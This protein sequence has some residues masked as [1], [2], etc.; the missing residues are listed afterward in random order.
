M[1]SAVS[2]FFAPLM[3]LFLVVSKRLAALRPFI[4]VFVFAKR[5]NNDYGNMI[6]TSFCVAYY[7]SSNWACIHQRNFA[8]FLDIFGTVKSV[9]S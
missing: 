3:A 9:W 4:K 6:A 7:V 2:L 8:A 5:N 1:P